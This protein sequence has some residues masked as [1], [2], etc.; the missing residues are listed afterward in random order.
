M[1]RSKA[2]NDLILT[3]IFSLLYSLVF[4]FTNI[5]DWDYVFTT[6]EVDL[7]ALV[8]DGKL[9]SWSYQMCGGSS[10]AGDPQ[11]YGF[12]P[13]MIFPLLFGSFWGAKSLLFVSVATGVHYL[14]K[15]I[16]LFMSELT[17]KETHIYVFSFLTCNF[18]LFHFSG[19]HLSFSSVFYAFPLLYL[20][21][22]IVMKIQLSNTDFLWNTVF[23]FIMMSGGFYQASIYFILP[24]AISFAIYLTLNFKSSNR[25]DILKLVGSSL[26]PLILTFYRWMPVLEYQKQFP[27][28]LNTF[29]WNNPLHQIMF[30]LLPINKR[31]YL[32]PFRPLEYSSGEDSYFGSVSIILLLILI[33]Y[34]KTLLRMFKQRQPIQDFALSLICVGLL[35]SLGNA[36]SFLPFTLLNNIFSGS[37]RVPG[38]FNLITYIGLFIVLIQFFKLH[39]V[40]KKI[41]S[42]WQFALVAI[43]LT[44]YFQ[45]YSID[46]LKMSYFQMQRIFE[47]DPIY[48]ER[49]QMLHVA[50]MRNGETSHMYIPTLLGVGVPNCYQPM[51]RMV[52]FMGENLGEMNKPIDLHFLNAEKSNQSESCLKMSYFTQSSLHI[53]PSCGPGTRINLNFI[54]P[55][56]LQKYNIKATSTGYYL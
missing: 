26:L 2:S 45:H 20:C 36:Y 38:R 55:E 1:A 11:S 51:T 31:E 14:K 41:L 4:V 24:L 40:E 13:L 54:Q 32:F 48:E 8:L 22:K 37:I 23:L 46:A 53:D 19:G 44:G 12:S 49:M 30:F 16:S 33:V 42:K 10:R 25:V 3:L 21:L 47:V 43:S 39:L 18:F 15:I 27:R 28:T 50:R 5:Y 35:L 34:F 29:E 6:L 56:Y 7:R 9:P 52:Y 17:S